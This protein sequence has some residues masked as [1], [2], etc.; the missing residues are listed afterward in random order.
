MTNNQWH[1]ITYV[2]DQTETGGVAIYIDGALDTSATN[3]QAWVWDT[4]QQIELGR[5]H[6]SYWRRYNGSMDDFMFYNRALTPAQVATLAAGTV[7]TSGLVCRLDFA[8]APVGDVLVDS[9]PAGLHPGTNIGV[10]W[11]ASEAGRN[12]VMQFTSI[13]VNQITVPPAEELNSLTTTITF[14]M[15]SA[16]NTDAGGHDGAIIF[17]HRT[18]AGDVIVMN[19]DGTLFV[20]ATYTGG[21]VVNQF[22]TVNVVNDDQW[23]HIAY[24]ADQTA[25]GQVQIYIDGVLDTAQA[26][27]HAW[28]WPTNQQIILGI[29]R[30]PYWRKYTGFL[31]EFQIYDRVLTGTQIGQVITDGAIMP[32]PFISVQ[33]QSVLVAPGAAVTRS[34][35]ATGTGT[36]SYQWQQNGTNRVGQTSAT[37]SLPSA[38]V[39]DTGTYRCVVTSSVGQSISLEAKL[40]VGVAPELAL[41]L[42]P[43]INVTGTVGLHYRVDYAEAVSPGTWLTLTDIAALPS[44]PFF[45]LDPQAAAYPSRFYRA[46]LLP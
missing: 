44:S 40:T 28:F 19:D 18:T 29:T 4:A 38:A 39:T 5:S 20:Q 30:A 13:P 22:A 7:D 21:G 46:L 14:W 17:D 15:K 37:L 12:G 33:P 1:H 34:V 42:Y 16:G 26:N 35:A 2:F 6:T 9:S 31:D 8:A 23:H 27:T 25:F 11:A 3:R 24:T 41:N 36:L 32:D 43:G 10:T 45:V